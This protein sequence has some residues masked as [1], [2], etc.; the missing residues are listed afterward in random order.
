MFTLQGHLLPLWQ[1]PLEGSFRPPSPAFK[2]FPRFL[3]LGVSAAYQKLT[4]GEE[5][6]EGDASFGSQGSLQQ[7]L[8]AFRG[9][10]GHE[11]VECRSRDES[12][13][14]ALLRSFRSDNV[15]LL[16]QLF[17]T[18]APTV[19][20]ERE[21]VCVELSPLA[22]E[23]NCKWILVRG[24]WPLR[25]SADKTHQRKPPE[26]HSRYVRSYSTFN[27]CTR[28]CLEHAWC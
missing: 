10:S 11:L 3:G 21:R 17:E 6:E 14:P 1:M 26:T 12:G 2:S 9:V 16:P 18:R 22:E 27:H 24:R 28:S 23:S 7:A 15:A 8:Q 5:A 20:V 13:F 4:E 25:L 19:V